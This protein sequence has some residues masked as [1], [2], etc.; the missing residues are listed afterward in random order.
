MNAILTGGGKRFSVASPELLAV[1][2]AVR[3]F[4]PSASAGVVARNFGKFNDFIG[5]TALKSA[6]KRES[7]TRGERKF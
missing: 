3:R 4:G 2:D 7:A 5:L 1:D 6:I